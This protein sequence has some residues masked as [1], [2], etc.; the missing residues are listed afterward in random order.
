MERPR[1]ECDPLGL[2]EPDPCADARQF[3]DGDS[4]PGAFLPE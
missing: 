4:A 1:R 2:A 3:L